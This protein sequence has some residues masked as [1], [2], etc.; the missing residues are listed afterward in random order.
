MA[1]GQRQEWKL[2][3]RRALIGFI[4]AGAVCFCSKYLNAD[5]S[6]NK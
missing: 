3:S 6:V 1:D 2:D 5:L 4:N